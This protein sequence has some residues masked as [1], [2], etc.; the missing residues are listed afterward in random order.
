MIISQK[1]KNFNIGILKRTKVTASSGL[2]LIL[3]FAEEIGVM[4]ELEKEFSHLKQ[5]E[6]G[7]S[8]SQLMMA[9]LAMF[10][11]GG[12][13]LSDINILSSDPGL[14]D[15]FRLHKF[16]NA[17]TLG[18]FGR[19]FTRRDISN[20]SELVMRL[21]SRMIEQM[22]LKEV[23][24][25]IDS[26]LIASDVC[27]SRKSYEGFYGFNPL[28]GIL[29][30]GDSFRAAG[31][32]VFRNGNAAPQS[33]NLSLLRKMVSYLRKHNPGLKLVVRIDSA[34]Y[35]HA[36]MK[37]CDEEGIEFVI[38]GEMYDIVVQTILR[39][40][41][42]SWEKL[43][44]LEKN[45]DHEEKENSRLEEVAESVHF[46]GGEKQ[47]SAYRFVAVRKRDEQKVLFPQYE[48]TYRAY[49]TNGERNKH[50]LVRLYRKRGDAENVIKEE[51]EGFGMDQI[52]SGDLLANAAFFQL[53]L[54]AYNLVQ[55]FKYANL[56]KNWW[57]LR[58]KQLRYR[59]INILGII[60]NHAR[61]TTLKLNKYYKY[62]KLFIRIYYQITMIRIEL[63]I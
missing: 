3:K 59:L 36:L 11:K 33:N 52:L 15:V 1:S 56:K 45:K 63:L 50:E 55:Y 29:K 31:F 37:Y 43:T 23:V 39:I 32:S 14:T 34:G 30:S 60:T 40:P 16:P 46:I 49:F 21:S 54:L 25:D 2:M 27:I 19:K 6:R 58:I 38:A 22:G 47:G 48:Y 51:K 28:M 4:K 41:Q 18:G 53:R 17:N 9:F 7:F 13:R 61:S 44:P 57:H 10:I 42:D 5:R 8:V 12:D 20:L 62:R 26:T 24:I 35:N